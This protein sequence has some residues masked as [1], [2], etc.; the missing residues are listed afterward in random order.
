VTSRYV[1]RFGVLAGTCL[2]GLGCARYVL[3]A[4]DVCLPGTAPPS[5]EGRILAVTSATISIKPNAE[6]EAAPVIVAVQ[7]ET[8]LFTAFGGYVDREE[9]RVG[10]YVWVWYVSRSPIWAGN[11][12]RAAVVIPY[13]GDPADQP[14]P[15][16]RPCAD[17][18]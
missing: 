3:P 6:V 7:N 16:D 9:L 10:Q 11:P 15:G 2:L 17:D 5:I 8:Q 13:W 1:G 14:S 12:P 18:R 4:G